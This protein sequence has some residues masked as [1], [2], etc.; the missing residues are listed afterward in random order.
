MQ[1]SWEKLTANSGKNYKKAKKGNLIQIKNMRK[2]KSSGFGNE[3]M[4]LF[5]K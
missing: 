4:K 3:K 1:F 5:E 2:E